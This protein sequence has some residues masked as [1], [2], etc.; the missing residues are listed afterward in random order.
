MELLFYFVLLSFFVYIL[1]KLVDIYFN[2]CK[3]INTKFDYEDFENT[4]KDK[5]EIHN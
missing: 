3:N 5:N 1:N 2:C 4:E